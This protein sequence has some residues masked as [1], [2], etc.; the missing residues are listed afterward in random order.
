MSQ[1]RQFYLSII[2]ITFL[3]NKVAQNNCNLFHFN[4]ILLQV[5]SK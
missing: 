3:E 5:A 4:R 1:L 2:T